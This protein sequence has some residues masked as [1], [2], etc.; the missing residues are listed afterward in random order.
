MWVRTCTRYNPSRF[1][2]RFPMAKH[3]RGVYF[4]DSRTIHR[5]AVFGS[6]LSVITFA[7][8]HSRT[9]TCY[10]WRGGYEKN[11][12]RRRRGEHRRRKRKKEKKT[13]LRATGGKEESN[14]SNTWYIRAA[15]ISYAG[16]VER[17]AGER[18][19]RLCRRTS[20]TKGAIEIRI[21]PKHITY[22]HSPEAQ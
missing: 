12:G 14:M 4:Q 13:R 19:R 8:T 9:H 21:R 20:H 6:L 2:I 16:H 15:V 5:V 10:A 1:A 18:V 17:V 22:H 3:F 7:D 11:K